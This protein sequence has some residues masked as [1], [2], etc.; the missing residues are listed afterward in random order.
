M[1]NYACHIHNLQWFDAHYLTGASWEIA[2]SS[3]KDFLSKSR[4]SAK[5][6]L[7]YE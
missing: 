3:L 4:K 5:D 2:A 7:I 6:A 1:T